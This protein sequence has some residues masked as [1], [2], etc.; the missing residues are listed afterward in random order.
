MHQAMPGQRREVTYVSRLQSMQAAID[1]QLEVRLPRAG[2]RCDRMCALRAHV[3]ARQSPWM[4]RRWGGLPW[5]S[6]ARAG[7]SG[8]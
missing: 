4:P 5:F 1:A 6:S 7:A 3:N 8:G 2:C